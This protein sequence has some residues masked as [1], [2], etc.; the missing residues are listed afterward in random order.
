M[1]STK[2]TIILGA[3]WGDEGKG[4]LTDILCPKF[5]VCARF[6]G[7]S[8]AGH[9]IW[10]NGVKYAVHLLPSGILTEDTIAVIGNGVVVH[11]ATLF[12]ELDALD[13]AGISWKGRLKISNRAHIVFDCHQQADKARDADAKLGTT[14]RGIGPCYAT[15]ML[16]TGI[17]MDQIRNVHTLLPALIKSLGIEVTQIE[18]NQEAIMHLHYADLLEGM[19]IDTS[20]YLHD[21]MSAGDT[22]LIESANAAMLDIDHGTYPYVTSSNATIGGALTGL[23][24]SMKTLANPDVIGIVKAYTTRVGNGPFPTELTL[25]TVIGKHLRDTGR[26]YGTTTGRS[27]RCGWLDLAIVRYTNVLNGYTSLCLTKL[28]VLTGLT[29]LMVCI[30]YHKDGI[31]L[32]SFPA[33]LEELAEVTPVYVTLPGWTE[34]ISG[35]RTISELPA[36]ARA[37]VAF[38]ETQIDVPVKWI[39]VGVTPEATIVL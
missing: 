29:E 21:C 15:K 2:T 12:K 4:K 33:S 11:L 26:E 3:Q 8:N 6:N 14:G 28:D 17:R 18:I 34:D 16:R 9:T 20:K 19:I 32:D 5:K 7:G 23:G 36:N 1:A 24:V 35:C 31:C 10:K 38:L 30:G 22:I 37:Y 25:D 13:A 27:R 39:G